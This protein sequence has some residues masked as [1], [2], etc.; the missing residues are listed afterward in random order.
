MSVYLT[1]PGLKHYR[2]E[3]AFFVITEMTFF[4]VSTGITFIVALTGM[5]FFLAHWDD[6]LLSAHGNELY[7]WLHVPVI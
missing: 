3:I 7:A 4:L 5:S 1:D 2:D 6:F